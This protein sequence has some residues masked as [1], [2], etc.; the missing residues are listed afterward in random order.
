MFNAEINVVIKLP[1]TN[2]TEFTLENISC[3]E[4]F[5]EECMDYLTEKN[6]VFNEEDIYNCTEYTIDY[7]STDTDLEEF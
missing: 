1:N 3:S 5:W 4:E 6:I 7:I 2:K